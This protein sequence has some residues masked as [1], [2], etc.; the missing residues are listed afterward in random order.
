MDLLVEIRRNADGVVATDMWP[1][2]AYHEYWWTCGN[3]SCDCNR[4]LFFARATH[5]PDP[6]ET[7]CGETR[8]SVRLSDADTDEILLNEFGSH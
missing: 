5:N 8:F 6:D 1:D 3:A 2:W 7:E 4:E